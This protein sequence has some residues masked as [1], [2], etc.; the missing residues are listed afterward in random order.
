MATHIKSFLNSDAFRL[1]NF[2]SER[3]TQCGHRDLTPSWEELSSGGGF[4][5]EMEEDILARMRRA[6]AG[7]LLECSIPCRN[8]A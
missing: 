1:Q 5:F 6:I 7:E 4:S 2:I 3:H 8:G